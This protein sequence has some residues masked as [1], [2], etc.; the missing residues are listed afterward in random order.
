MRIASN[1]ETTTDIYLFPACHLKGLGCASL[2]GR[3]ATT[4]VVVV[5]I[6]IED[7]QDFSA[8]NGN[9]GSHAE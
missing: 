5:S 6:V 8:P 3:K 4:L 1:S 7:M 2:L 9:H